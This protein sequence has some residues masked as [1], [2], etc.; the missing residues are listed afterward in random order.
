MAKGKEYELAIKIAGEVEKSLQNSINMSTKQIKQMAKDASASSNS[1]KS[2][3]NEGFQAVN[4]GVKNMENVAKKAF[5]AT[6]MAATAAATA[7]AAI[8]AQAIKYG[9]AFESQMSTVQAISGATGEEFKALEE[10][11]KEMGKTT[12][13]SASESAK[14]FE[15]MAM[16]G[17]KTDQMLSGIEGVM[18]LAAASGEE[19]G[20]VSDIVTDALTALK[21]SA[22]DTNKFVDILAATA[23]N[24]NTNVSMLGE[25]FKYVAATAGTLGYSAEDLSIALGTMANSGVKGTQAGNALKTA[26]ARMAK[27]TDAVASAMDK[28]GISMTKDNGETKSLMEVM[29]NLRSSIGSVNVDLVDSEG[30]LREYDSIVEDLSKTTEGLS[31]V[32]Q[33]EAAS[34]IFGK[35]AMAGMLTIVNAGEEDFSKLSDAINN[36]TG[37]AEQM[38][39]TRLDNLNGD[40]TLFKS[41]MEGLNIEIYDNIKEPLRDVVQFATNEI[42][43]FTEKIQKSGVIKR[44]LNNIIK[45][46]PTAK[47]KISETAKEVEKLST[48]LLKIGKWILAHPT[49]IKSF[50]VGIGT[51]MITY[52]VSAGVMGLANSFMTLSSVF[53]NPFVLAITAVGLAIGGAAGLSYYIKKCKEEAVKANLS[54]HFGNITMSLEDLKEVASYILQNQ[55]LGKLGEALS[56]MD[57]VKDIAKKLND[58]VEDL[59]KLNWKVS[60]GMQ[61]TDDEKESY[62]SSITD[63][64]NQTQDLLVQKQYALNLNLE[65]FTD[66][67]EQGQ[68]IRDRVNQF[69]S[70]N[71]AEL[72][73]LGTQLNEAVNKAFE[74]GLLDI[75]EVKEITQLQKQMADIKNQIASSNFESELEVIGLKFSGGELDSESFQNLQ[76][77]LNEQV[78]NATE[79]LNEGLK[80]SIAD[81]KVRLNAGSI[82]QSQYEEEVRMYKENY[83]NQITDLTLRAKE[84]QINTIKEQYSEELA[85]IDEV[86]KQELGGSMEESY[87]WLTSATEWEKL[88]NNIINSDKI[89]DSTRS[90]VV[91]LMGNLKPTDDSL[92]NIANQYEEL[93][94]TIPENLSKGLKNDAALSNLTG[95]Y[96]SIMTTLANEIV[97]NPQYLS[98]IE[99]AQERGNAIPEQ[100]AAAIQNNKNAISKSINEMYAYT[101]N[102]PNAQPGFSVKMS[103]ASI[104]LGTSALPGYANGD[105]ITKPTVATFAENGP[106][107]AIPLNKSP[108][109]ISLWKKAGQILGMDSKIDNFLQEPKNSSETLNNNSSVI[110]FSPVLN[111]NGGTPSQSD[112]SNAMKLSQDE[113]ESMMNKYIKNNGRVSFG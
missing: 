77:E 50:I 28:L 44:T 78:Q 98:V 38:A 24:S 90:A 112:I 39:D 93:G 20:M 43:T 54:E 40:V 104:L 86:I 45:Q 91:K 48:P 16:A 26:L 7:V 97:N 74:D 5:Q 11:A 8:T 108:R 51:S 111:F 113:F 52:K 10:K 61:L 70:N 1:I 18:N 29:K 83:L 6:A 110:T 35:N 81:A 94:T 84:F 42:S 17:W 34:T 12:V 59:N 55:S 60:I 87:Q 103:G 109:A 19:L 107:A 36:C 82:D 65:I 58:T 95:D 53:S 46:L 68:A 66:D 67:N 96:N 2:Q 25:S 21:Y 92:K 72:Q 14:A 13:F 106:E 105:I 47:R 101:Q 76:A 9:S 57:N 71:Y 27:P 102:S 32:Q 33:I 99:E 79:Q 15:Y 37:A 89:S 56:S 73:N 49:L 88:Y 30:N 22:E 4:N 64:I 63:Y 31:R 69:Y 85:Q 62:M 41:A 23:T 100:M 3:F 80:L 75:D